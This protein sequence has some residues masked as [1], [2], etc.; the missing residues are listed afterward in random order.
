M[1]IYL[2]DW[3]RIC[4]QGRR[5]ERIRPDWNRHERT[6]DL[7]EWNRS[8]LA[9]GSERLIDWQF[10]LPDRSFDQ[11]SAMNLPSHP[12]DSIHF[13]YAMEYCRTLTDSLSRSLSFY[14]INLMFTCL[15]YLDYSIHTHIHICCFLLMFSLGFHVW[16]FSSNSCRINPCSVPFQIVSRDD[17]D[18]R[19]TRRSGRRRTGAKRSIIW[20][21]EFTPRSSF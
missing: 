16:S 3:D 21:R 1:S 15:S 20:K 4:F 6:T 5:E 12:F 18:Q 7:P 2:H 10:F 8:E 14:V 9:I 17:I 11:F 19:L 13:F